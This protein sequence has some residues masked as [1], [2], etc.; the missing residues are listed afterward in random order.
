MSLT[1]PPPPKSYVGNE[2]KLKSNH[3][4][5]MLVSQKIHHGQNE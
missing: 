1:V 4:L 5:K 2:F 3:L